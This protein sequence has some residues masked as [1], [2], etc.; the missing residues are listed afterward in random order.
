MQQCAS[1]VR[2]MT[3]PWSPK[4][5]EEGAPE[6]GYGTTLREQGAL[7]KIVCTLTLK[8]MGLPTGAAPPS[9]G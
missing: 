5:E 9:H 3:Q 4:V 1:S 2:D 7:G 8:K 6:G